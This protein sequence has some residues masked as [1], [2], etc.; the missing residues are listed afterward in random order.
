MQRRKHIQLDWRVSFTPCR[1]KDY[2]EKRHRY[3]K[4][5]SNNKPNRA[6]SRGRRKF[7]SNAFLKSFSRLY[8]SF[9]FLFSDSPYDLSY[10][11]NLMGKKSI[12]NLGI[13][14]SWMPSTA[15]LALKRV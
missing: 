15:R 3:R 7:R 9:G 10:C 11:E 1:A 12:N 2:C 4:K 6:G 13:K 5:D 8:I 14:V